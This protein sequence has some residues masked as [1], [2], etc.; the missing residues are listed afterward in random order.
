MLN[1]LPWGR[2]LIVVLLTD[3]S[4][5][6]SQPRSDLLAAAIDSAAPALAG[7][8]TFERAEASNKRLMATI[9][10]GCLGPG[11]RQAS[12]VERGAPA[13]PAAGATVSHRMVPE[14]RVTTRVAGPRANP[15]ARTVPAARVIDV[16]RLVSTPIRPRPSGP[17]AAPRFVASIADPASAKPGPVLEP[18]LDHW[19]LAAS[20]PAPGLYRLPWGIA[21]YV[22]SVE[23]P[24]GG[25]W[26]FV[27]TTRSEHDRSSR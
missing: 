22:E 19:S 12:R 15:I 5:A 9:C 6:F 24:Q 3:A 25:R 2:I 1:G 8:R 11:M 18:I 23:T 17:I 4:P 10:E 21:R 13:G 26:S 20:Q 16:P 7:R 14:R 27:A